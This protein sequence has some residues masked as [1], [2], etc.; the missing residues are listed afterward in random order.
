MALRFDGRVAVVTGGA[1]GL[2]RAYSA[3]LAARGAAVVVVD[4]GTD[5]A[6]T[7]ASTAPAEA[8]ADEVRAAGGEA[9]SFAGDVT[10]AAGGEAI[11]EHA[12]ASYGRI[13]ILINNAGILRDRSF[14]RLGEDDIRAVLDVHL[15]G[16]FNVTKPAW[17]C[18]RAQRYGRIVNTTS[19]SGLLGNFGQANYAAAKMGIVGLTRALALEGARHGI[20]VNAI[21]PLAR[22]RM[23]EEAL[24]DAAADLDPQLAAPVA[25]WLAHESCPVTGEIYSAAGGRVARYFIGLTSGYHS[26]LLTPEEVAEHLDTIRSTS[27]A[28]T[29]LTSLRDELELVRQFVTAQSPAV[30]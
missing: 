14:G 20:A 2:G 23:S 21:A 15:L 9:V 26:P 11:I 30:E 5:V 10:D 3:L 24:A 6:G 29:D 25:A 4:L 13:D 7:G 17:R 28:S 18:M 16:T 12:V 27:G 22:T 19:A 1:G 8:V